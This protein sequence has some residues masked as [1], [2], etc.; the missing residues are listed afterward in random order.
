MVHLIIR[1]KIV[2]YIQ[3]SCHTCLIRYTRIE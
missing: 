1:H 2:D 3:G